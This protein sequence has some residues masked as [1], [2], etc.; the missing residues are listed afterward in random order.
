VNKL[1][2]IGR[3]VAA[4]ID[5]LAALAN[6]IVTAAANKVESVLAT[7]LSLA[8][9]FL[10]NFAGLGNIPKKVVEIIKKIRAPVDK[11]LDAVVK[12]IVDKAKKIGSMI[13][14]AGAP[15]DPEQRVKLAARD[16]KAIA[17]AL[18]GDISRPILERA[19]AVVK[20]RYSL[21]A[22]IITES[23]GAFIA[24]AVINPRAKVQLTEEQKDLL[25]RARELCDRLFKQFKVQERLAARVTG[26]GTRQDPI[27]MP[28]GTGVVAV[29]KKIEASRAGTGEVRHFDVTQGSDVQQRGSVQRT[30]KDAIAFGATSE[31]GR[32]EIG[33][34]RDIVKAMRANLSKDESESATILLRVLRNEPLGTDLDAHGAWI[35]GI[36]TLAALEIRRDPVA[37]ASLVANLRLVEAQLLTMRQVFLAAGKIRTDTGGSTG[38]TFSPSPAGAKAAQRGVREE[39]GMPVP[40]TAP[41][42]RGTKAQRAGMM[43]VEVE[44]FTK[45]A[46]LK[47]KKKNPTNDEII[48]VLEIEI[49]AILK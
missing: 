16:A 49:R 6:G 40:A 23:G 42:S 29:A 7:G 21:N 45:L 8:I 18:R 24:E 22:L 33:K 12:W 3:L 4:F 41:K 34:Y 47:L 30:E 38:G 11:A 36:K 19:L 1:A 35:G 28:E 13:L 5:G 37:M 48:A 9:S 31:G 14:Q 32:V 44:S 17:S 26:R 15:T 10:A 43:A 25:K 39:L 2:E 46:I 20:T 27:V